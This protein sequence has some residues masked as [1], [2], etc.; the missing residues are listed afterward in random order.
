MQFLL[1]A[2]THEEDNTFA[3]AHCDGIFVGFRVKAWK[4]ESEWVGLRDVLWEVDVGGGWNEAEGFVFP[5][6]WSLFGV[7]VIVEG[8]VIFGCRAG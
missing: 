6:L 3:G 2:L 8:Q 1:G 4:G 7:D 5:L